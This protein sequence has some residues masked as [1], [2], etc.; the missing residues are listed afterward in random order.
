MHYPD[1]NTFRELARE[2][3]LIPVYRR[4]VSDTLTPVTAFHKI[5]TGGSACL[6]ESVIGGEKVGRYSFLAADPFLEIAARE[7]QVSISEAGRTRQ[8]TAA[9]PLQVLR[10]R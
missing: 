10:Q 4:L 3:Q 8:F 5:D 1:W 6:F 9:D 7:T 2:Y